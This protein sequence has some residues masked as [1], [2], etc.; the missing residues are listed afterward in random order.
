MYAC[1]C[2]N[3]CVRTC[4]WYTEGCGAVGYHAGWEGERR[5]NKGHFHGNI[6]LVRGIKK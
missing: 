6:E 1:V 5:G 3:V 2:V 4:V